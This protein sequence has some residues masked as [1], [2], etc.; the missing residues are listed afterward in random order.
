MFQKASL[1]LGPPLLLITQ[2][3]LVGWMMLYPEGEHEGEGERESKGEDHGERRRGFG[4][5]CGIES[6]MIQLPLIRRGGGL[7]VAAHT[8]ASLPHPSQD[9]TK[10][11][12]TASSP[13]PTRS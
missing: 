12:S 11:C 9:S 13:T 3:G 10:R 8:P 6:W 2:W 7:L 4:G 1:K 5:G